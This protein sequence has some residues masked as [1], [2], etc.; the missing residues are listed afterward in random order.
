MVAFD[1]RVEVRDART[2]EVRHSF[3]AHNGAVLGAVFAGPDHDFIWT[4]GR[5]GTAIAL[6]L[7]GRRGLIRTSHVPFAAHTGQA[8]AGGDTAVITSF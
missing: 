8:A 3:T 6:D 2:L 7:T 1:D 5:D 4:A